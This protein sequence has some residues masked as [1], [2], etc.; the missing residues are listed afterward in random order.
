[1]EFS[2]HYKYE[3]SQILPLA[4][5]LGEISFKNARQ[6]FSTFPIKEKLFL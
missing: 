1:M 6:E 5:H 4:I 3:I 2:E